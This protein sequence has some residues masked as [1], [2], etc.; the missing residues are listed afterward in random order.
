MNILL[1]EA[2]KQ[3]LSCLLPDEHQQFKQ[4]NQ[5]GASIETGPEG[6]SVNSSRGSTYDNTHSSA[7]SKV[8]SL[9]NRLDCAEKLKD[10]LNN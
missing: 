2:I 9:L 5:H 6:I 10:K 3:W 1:F 4:T 8:R 7:I